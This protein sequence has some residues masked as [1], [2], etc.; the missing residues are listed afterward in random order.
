MLSSI[1]VDVRGKGCR[2][3]SAEVKGLD[4]YE[5]KGVF[6]VNEGGKY[7]QTLHKK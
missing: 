1:V 4:K 6:K 3:T 7:S 5:G 2:K